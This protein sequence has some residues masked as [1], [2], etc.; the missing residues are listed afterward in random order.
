MEKLMIDSIL[1]W[2]E[3]YK[4]DSFRFDL[5]GHHSLTNMT[6]IQNALKNPDPG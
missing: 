1:L 6:R 2:A 5:M 4:I 3:A